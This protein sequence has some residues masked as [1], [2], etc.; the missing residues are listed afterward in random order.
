MEFVG[1]LLTPLL[2]Q[3]RRDD[4]QKAPLAFSPLLGD[5]Q[6]SFDRLSKPDLVGENRTA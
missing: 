3:I 6:P 1:Q 2:A 4:D 5:Q